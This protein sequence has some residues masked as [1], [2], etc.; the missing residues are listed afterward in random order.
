MK[1]A[2]KR[3]V[4]KR[5]GL[6]CEYCHLPKRFAPFFGFH[7]EHVCPKKHGGGNK[8]ANLAFACFRCNLHE[9]P[10]LSG[11]DPL[12]GK[13]VRLFNPRRQKWSRHF[14]WL[15]P[16]L[17]GRTPIGRATI[18]VLDINAEERVEL[19]GRLIRMGHKLT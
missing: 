7:I 12:T 4:R 1:A 11:V 9:G 8:P 13:V 3:L 16:E 10:N 15:G 17:I 5:A 14:S 6:R 2:L 19:R 18:N